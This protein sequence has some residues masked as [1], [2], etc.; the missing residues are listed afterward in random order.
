MLPFMWISGGW[1]AKIL[2]SA[3]CEK[4]LLHFLQLEANGARWDRVTADAPNPAH[5]EL[6]SKSKTNTYKY[7]YKETD[8]HSQTLLQRAP[9]EN[10]SQL[11]NF[12][13]DR[14]NTFALDPLVCTYTHTLTHTLQ[15]LCN[16]Y[17]SSC[18]EFDGKTIEF[19]T[20]FEPLDSGHRK[21]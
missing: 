13:H 11:L 15:E 14:V 3:M 9:Q 18:S 6:I 12:R 7:T 17:N 4:S 21:I 2:M 8:A 10:P 5:L 16:Y 19:K 20:Y 1:T